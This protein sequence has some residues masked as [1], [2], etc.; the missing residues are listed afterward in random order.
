M[1]EEKMKQEIKM[2][3]QQGFLPEKIKDNLR[4]LG[5]PEKDVAEVDKLVPQ[6][7]KEVV[8]KPEIVEKPPAV[9]KAVVPAEEAPEPAVEEEGS[10]FPAAEEA[11]AP[12]EGED[13]ADEEAAPEGEAPEE[14]LSDEE[15]L[16]SFGAEEEAE[17]FV[18]EAPLE[19]E[20]KPEESAKEEVNEKEG[21]KKEEEKP[22]PS[23]IG[24]LIVKLVLVL[25]FLGLIAVIALIAASK[26]GIEIPSAVLDAVPPQVAEYLPI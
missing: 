24:G 26:F 10:I 5:Y 13:L 19:P 6:K 11:V 22:K 12:E 20:K 1:L 23:G 2:L 3:I 7:K 9:E 25:I 17:P 18:R 8:K 16:L 15:A 21:E 4:G 14:E